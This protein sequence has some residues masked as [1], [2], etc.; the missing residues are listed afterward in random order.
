MKTLI[1][2]SFLFIFSFAHSQSPYSDR[3]NTKVSSL[4]DE[5]FVATFEQSAYGI[6]FQPNDRTLNNDLKTKIERFIKETNVSKFR[7]LGTIKLEIIKRNGLY[8]VVEET[9]PERLLELK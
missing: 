3:A 5:A 4:N 1:I 6:Q 7:K 9:S 2:L 8:Y